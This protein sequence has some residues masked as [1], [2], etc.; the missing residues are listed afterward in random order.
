MRLLHTGQHHEATMKRSFFDQLHIPEP[1]I[2]LGVG[3][4]SHAVKTAEIMK[5]FESVIDESKPDTTLV[6]GDIN[7]TLACALVAVKNSV[8]I[9]HVGAGL[10]NGD[11]SMPMLDKAFEPVGL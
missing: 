4:G 1:D 6:V 3:S 5:R 11:R 2:D 9:I 7:S 8:P 10:R